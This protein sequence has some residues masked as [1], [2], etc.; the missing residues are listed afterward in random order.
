MCTCVF[1]FVFVYVCVGTALRNGMSSAVKELHVDVRR[2]L[3]SDKARP[4]TAISKSMRQVDILKI[5]PA[6]KYTI[7]NTTKT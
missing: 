2:Q 3:R 1:V 4:G 5:Q 7:Y 6:T